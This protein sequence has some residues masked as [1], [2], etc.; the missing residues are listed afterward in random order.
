ME[1]L[2]RLA[3]SAGVTPRTRTN[4]RRMASADLKPQE[5]AISLRP[6]RGAVDD[7]LGGFDTHAV[8]K[9]AG[10][11]ACFAETDA[12]EVAGAHADAIGERI[13]GEVFAKMFDHPNLKLAQGLGGDG[14]M[15]EHVAEL[16]LASGAHEEHDEV[17][18]D[19]EGGFV[20][21][22]LLDEGE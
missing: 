17:A 20:A 12:G 14:L 10:V 15:G 8:D 16:S 18:G 5:S 7:L 1:L 6:T 13:D 21:V 22:I 11:H 2:K 4:V 3:Y 19:A 9:L